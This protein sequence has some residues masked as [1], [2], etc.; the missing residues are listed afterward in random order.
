MSYSVVI[1]DRKI[2]KNSL[3]PKSNSQLVKAEL[4]SVWK[5]CL[6]SRMFPGK[7]HKRVID[8]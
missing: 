2:K 1:F 4:Y 3:L 7:L 5:R 6:I 8:V